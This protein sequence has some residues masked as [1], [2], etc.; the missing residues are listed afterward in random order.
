VVAVL[1]AGVFL[2][3]ASAAPAAIVLE[4]GTLSG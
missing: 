3:L 4:E 2:A 1:A